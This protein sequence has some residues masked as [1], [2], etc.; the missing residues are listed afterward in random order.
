MADEIDTAQLGDNMRHLESLYISR[1]HVPA[2][3]ASGTCLQCGDPV[4]ENRR[5]CGFD[6][7]KDWEKENP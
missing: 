2:T 5:W 7:M 4:S 6:C 1:R 3:V